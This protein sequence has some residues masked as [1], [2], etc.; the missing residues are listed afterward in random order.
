FIEGIIIMKGDN[1]RAGHRIEGASVLDIT[2]TLLALNGFPVAED[3]DGRVLGDALDPAFIDENP[4]TTIDSYGPPAWKTDGEV[5]EYDERKV[6][7]KLRTLGY[8]D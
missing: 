1:I 4:V 6:R 2:P 3:M 8:L 5:Y 7:E